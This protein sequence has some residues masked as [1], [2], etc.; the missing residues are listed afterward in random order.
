MSIR[1]FDPEG[2]KSTEYRNKYPELLDIDE[3]TSLNSKELILVWWF[4]NPTSPLFNIEGDRKRMA[5]A[6]DRAKYSTSAIKRK[7]LLNMAFSENMAL[8]IERMKKFLPDYRSRAKQL[9]QD[10]FK[11]YETIA[12][13]SLEDYTDKDGNPDRKK[14]VDTTS[15]IIEILPDLLIKLESGFGITDEEVEGTGAMGYQ[16]DFFRNQ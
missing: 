1:L 8:A 15:K 6:L 13:A 4:S 9:M 7:E 2:I 12:N 10:M 5:E 11:Q 14:Y 16:R 3:F